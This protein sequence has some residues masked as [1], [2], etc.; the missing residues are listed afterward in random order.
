MTNKTEL[1]QEFEAWY[2]TQDI[3][4][5]HYFFDV[6]EIGEY[7][8]TLLQSHF[9]MYKTIKSKLTEQLRSEIE[10][11]KKVPVVSDEQIENIIYQC[12]GY[13]NWGVET[14]GKKLICEKIRGIIGGNHD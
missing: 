7:K 1:M 11:L 5:V 6:N 9:D 8:N 2:E 12:D 10:S 4:F 3:V 14:Q 13:L